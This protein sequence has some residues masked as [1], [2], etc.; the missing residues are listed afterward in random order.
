MI[1]IISISKAD[2]SFLDFVRG[3]S[4]QLVLIGHLL[5]LYGIDKQYTN[6]PKIQNFGVVVFFIVSGFL[7]TYISIIKGKQYGF[8]NFMID[9]FSRIYSAFFPALVLIFCIDLYL[10]AHEV[11]DYE[12][13]NYTFSN[14]LSNLFLLNNHPVLMKFFG[15]SAYGSARPL[16]TVSIEWMFYICFG[17]LFFWNSIMNKANVYK[18]SIFVFFLL[19]PIFYVS[20]R[21]DGLTVY[22]LLGVVLALLYV[23]NIKILNKNYLNTFLGLGVFIFFYRLLFSK[24]YVIYDVG[25]A[26]ILFLLFYIVFSI[27]AKQSIIAKFF[28]KS[29]SINSFFAS[30]SFSL[31]LVHYSLIYLLFS[32]FEECNLAVSVF[33]NVIIINLTALL[34]YYCF[35]RNYILV[36]ARI[37][38]WVNFSN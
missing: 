2:S 20:S 28:I 29:K 1:K 16:W 37:K 8:K 15:S 33:L 36:R 4:A 35:E 9:R 18:K 23:N 7:I 6:L 24:I 11:N 32:F 25:L 27:N 21:G 10:K 26:L 34:F 30:Y 19:P 14:L 12:T 5:G 31:Y 13:F 38:K 17:I 22:W 3:I